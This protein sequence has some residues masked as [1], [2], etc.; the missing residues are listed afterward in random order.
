MSKPSRA[1]QVSKAQARRGLWAVGIFLVLVAVL[2]FSSVAKA[3]DTTLTLKVLDRYVG[4]D[5]AEFYGGPVTQNSVAT[6]WGNV[7]VDL[8]FSTGLDNT[9]FWDDFDDEVN[10]SGWYE[11]GCGPFDYEVG[12]A[13]Y[14]LTDPGG[15]VVT[16]W[17]RTSHTFEFG[18]WSLTPYVKAETYQPVEGDTPDAGEIYRLG[19][20]WSWQVKP[21][22]G[23]S[24]TAGVFYDTGAFG[25]DSG[26]LG[27]GNLSLNWGDPEGQVIWTFPQVRYYE[28]IDDLIDGRGAEWVVGSVLTIKLP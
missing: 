18:A 22:F 1:E 20:D 23:V 6:C 9:D 24:G 8:W 11:N 16:V 21:K 10:A 13:F 27:E 2:F 3:A 26:L 5:G 17:F 25:L 19:S 12:V 7:C 14:A 15:D 4:T 28:P